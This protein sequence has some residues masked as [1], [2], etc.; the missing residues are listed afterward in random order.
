MDIITGVILIGLVI[1]FIGA[2]FTNK[3]ELSIMSVLL[4]FCS[5][6]AITKDASIPD[7]LVT[8]LYVPIVAIGLFSI[9][10]FFKAKAW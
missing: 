10:S 8:I 5:F 3:Y 9:A 4:V 7:D 1:A 6:V 2:I